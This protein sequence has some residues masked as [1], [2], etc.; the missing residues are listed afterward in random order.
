[1]ADVLQIRASEEAQAKFKALADEMGMKH[2]D[3][4]AVMMNVYESEKAAQLV[5]DMEQAVRDFSAYTAQMQRLFNDA[6]VAVG[7]QRDLARESVRR[8][9]QSKDEVILGLQE[10]LEEAE[11]ATKRAAALEAELQELRKAHAETLTTVTALTAIRDTLPDAAEVQQMRERITS[12]E[13]ICKERAETIEILK[14]AI[15]N[16]QSIAK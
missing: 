16:T 12:L 14:G 15:G 2:G 6:V 8:E 5:P 13:A 7:M 3:A 4:L 11:Q 9:L 1:M 10:K